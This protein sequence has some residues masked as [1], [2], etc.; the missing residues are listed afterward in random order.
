MKTSSL[1]AVCLAVSLVPVGIQAQNTVFTYQGRVTAN[2]TNFNGTGRFKFALVTSTN[3]SRQATAT[4]NMGGISP[5]QFV[6]SC[7][8]GNGGNGYTAAAGVTFSGGGGSGAT[9]TANVSGGVVIS[10]TVLTPGSGYSSAP[11]VTVAAPPD[12]ILFTTFWS[13][14][15][16]SVNGSEPS[17]FVTVGVSNGLF[18][19]VLGDTTILNMAAISAAL[20]TQPNLQL[21]IWFNDGVNGFA[22]L[23]PAQNLTP[24]PYAVQ[25][26]N[27][28]TATTATTAVS[29]NSVAAANIVGTLTPS[30]VQGG[31]VTNNQTGV[32]LT[33]NFTGNGGSLSNLSP[34]SLVLF[35]TNTSVTGW[36][37]NNSGQRSIPSGL[38]D[39]TKIAAGFIHSLGLRANG[40]VVA[41]GGGKTIDT[42]SFAE[43]GQSLI[44]VGVSNVQ[45]VAAGFAHSLA[46]LTNGTVVAWGAGKTNNPS[47]NRDYGQ[48]IVPPGLPNVTSISAG[49][50][51]NLV[52]TTNG[53]VVAWGAGTTINPTNGIEYGQSIVPPG[54]S[55]IVAVSVGAVHSLI[56]KS[57]KTVMAWG[58]GTTNNPGNGI[59][60]GQ[61]ILPVGL[62]NVVAISAGYLHNLAL[63]SDGTVVAW[64]A[65]T[66]NDGSGG[67][68]NLGQSMVPVGLS[69]VVAI[70]AG[71]EHSLALKSD[72]TVVVWGG[73]QF[74]E[75]NAPVGLD[76]VL[77][78]APGP[79]AEHILVLRK[80]SSAPVAWLDSD[81]TFKGSIQINNDLQVGGDAR[82]TGELS[83]GGLRLSDSNLWLRASP[84]Q[85]NGLGWYGDS[86]TFGSAA[87][88][89]P[90]LFGLSGGA[91]G[92]TTNSLNVAL[93]WDSS[94]N[95]GIG[96]TTPSARLSLG[97]DFADS[98]FL[99]R[100]N[101]GGIG[102]GL[103]AQSSQLRFHLS[104]FGSDRFSFLT[105]PSGTEVCSISANGIVK[106]G[107]TAQFFAT[108][109]A[110]N[111]R[112]IRGH[113]N[114]AGGITTG[115]GFT[116][117]KTGTG[118]YTVTFT[119][120]FTSEPTVTATPQVGLARIATCTNVGAGSAQFRT[121]DVS[122]S[123]AT[124]IDQDFHFIA[125]GP[126]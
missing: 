42:N 2:G 74:G 63:K 35:S 53:T 102:F 43:A 118:A 4:A 111:L 75:T 56:L 123:P 57:N 47:N 112:I 95:V 105:A 13:N 73:N 15:G 50:G 87:P 84:D 106:F 5:N 21:R 59:D 66:T 12:N 122:S 90:V 18:T 120:A 60:F 28:N 16:T 39:V 94:Q 113:I 6:S 45:A 121:F 71:V 46:L 117:T 99:V 69:N 19:V 116:V 44:P 51:H 114:S 86:K 34:N 33:G 9:A 27:A 124:A 52:L 72:G 97:S 125:V 96:T 104:G 10:I 80:R 92:T 78:L 3:T 85:K 38:D 101:G 48:S 82:I 70:V 115:S 110:E 98:K 55:N 62:S 58:A 37:Q 14:D 41:W 103:G 91:L 54:L 17:A 61:S 68:F 49:Y 100:D 64:G 88:N 32:N 23:N 20:F 24:A 8:V 107:P 67:G 65:G 30:Q 83:A 89:G 7:S 81:N 77:A 22:A 108:G 26:I 93:A 109:G 76:N 1:F 11:L 31:A 126:R 119:T 29:A 79:I 25:A 36:G 40:T